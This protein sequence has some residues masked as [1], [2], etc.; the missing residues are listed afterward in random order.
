MDLFSSLVV[1]AAAT[2]AEMKI[3]RNG[4]K[5]SGIYF[6]E[7]EQK[8]FLAVLKGVARLC[9]PLGEGFVWNAARDLER[10]LREAEQQRLSFSQ[11][12]H[13]C[14]ACKMEI[15]TRKDAYLHRK[16]RYTHQNCPP[17]KDMKLR[18]KS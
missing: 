11:Y 18:G 1:V 10:D 4:I 12:F 14:E 9:Q 5:Y 8:L 15:D 6:D 16:D 13:L 17:L 3:M 2:G 7:K